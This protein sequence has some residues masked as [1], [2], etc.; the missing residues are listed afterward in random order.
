[1]F[2]TF[3]LLGDIMDNT[4]ISI[5]R[6][7]IVMLD[8]ENTII[9]SWHNCLPLNNKI[10][11]IKKQ[12]TN[13]NNIFNSIEAYGIFSF[14]VDHEYEKSQARSIATFVTSLVFD[15][16]FTTSFDDLMKI[17]RFQTP[18]R[19]GRGHDIRSSQTLLSVYTPIVTPG[20]GSRSRYFFI[21]R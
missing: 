16:D 21:Y 8:L 3:R 15:P 13:I 2:S 20:A 4:P 18:R 7:L 11:E 12:I 5:R 1:M 17:C 6:P 10:K 14:A 19:A 9:D